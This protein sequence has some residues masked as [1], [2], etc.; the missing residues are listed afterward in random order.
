MII[1]KRAISYIKH[2]LSSNDLLDLF[3]KYV[4]VNLAQLI[5]R[6]K[7][8]NHKVDNSKFVFECFQGRNVSDSPLS[9]YKELMH[10]RKDL[11]FVWVLNSVEHEL[12]NQLNTSL[13]TTVIIYGTKEYDIEYATAG[14]WITNCR[15]PFR[16]F[17]K[18]MQK[19]IQCWHGTPLKKLGY[20]IEV[21]TNAINS[22][23]G[24][25]YGYHIDSS[26]YD[27]FIS[28]S[29]Y[30]TD[31]FLTGFQIPED[32]VIELGYPRNDYLVE[33]KDNDILI[34]E[35]KKKL[36]ISEDKKVILYAPTWRDDQYSLKK[37][38]HVLDNKLDTLDFINQFDISDTI[39]LYRGHYF[40]TTNNINKHFL[41]VSS[42]N[43]VNELFLISDALITD[44]S[45][46]FFDFAILERP[47]YFYMY[48]R[49][50][51]ENATRG[52]YIDIDNELPGEIFKDS[53][54]LA[55][56]LKSNVNSDKHDFNVV[57]N[58]HEDGN[59]ASRVI[60]KIL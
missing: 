42:Y 49:D 58:L 4:V 3:S 12:Y 59:S 13:N 50:N 18:K 48:D 40:T 1:K 39:F 9:I 30:A 6:I 47:I 31:C 37:T 38:T 24:L 32:K 16:F 10:T 53:I 52:F 41:D 20:D 54:L 36:G 33:N 22:L 8:L 5:F 57:Y 25:R 21:G 7:Y 15:L 55:K 28:P 2:K 26:R 35:I 14:Y 34:R 27:Y 23:K 11:S 60:D 43:D 19:Y 17:K 44:Y 46:V 56:A 51:Y 45:S 29:K